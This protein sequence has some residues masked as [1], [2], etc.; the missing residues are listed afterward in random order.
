MTTPIDGVF[1][2]YGKANITDGEDW[3]RLDTLEPLSWRLQERGLGSATF[4][5]VDHFTGAEQSDPTP[6]SNLA[7][8]LGEGVF[9]VMIVNSSMLTD[10]LAATLPAEAPTGFDPGTLEW[11]GFLRTAPLL[12]FQNGG[13]DGL[14][15]G[16]E[17]GHYLLGEPIVHS[18]TIINGYN[19]V[20]DGTMYG[21]RLPLQETS[22]RTD[23]PER[24]WT[25]RQVV[26][27][28]A[29]KTSLS[30]Q[31]DWASEPDLLD[32]IESWPSYEGESLMTALEQ[33]IGPM[34]WR[35]DI[36]VDAN[37]VAI[38]VYSRSSYLGMD[39]EVAQT[40]STDERTLDLRI[41]QH[42]RP[43]DHIILRGQ[44]VLTTFTAST[45]GEEP[46]LVQGWAPL[47]ETP[48]VIGP[49]EAISNEDL[50]AEA[51]EALGDFDPNVWD[52]EGEYQTTLEQEIQR[53]TEAEF[54]RNAAW[55]RLNYPNM[56]VRYRWNYNMSTGALENYILPG[57]GTGGA[58]QSVPLS[59]DD[60]LTPV[61]PAGR[62]ITPFPRF[63][64]Q[65]T[66]SQELLAIP[67]VDGHAT[68]TRTDWTPHPTTTVP[69]SDD[70]GE[71]VGWHQPF[72]AMRCVGNISTQRRNDNT[73][74]RKQQWVDLTLPASGIQTGE[75]RYDGFAIQIDL[76]YPESLAA[77]YYDT[78]T[79]L[80]EVSGSGLAIRWSDFGRIQPTRWGPGPAGA[81]AR[82]PGRVEYI[83]KGHWSRIIFTI[84]VRSA[85]YVQL[86]HRFVAEPQRVKIVEDPDL[87]YWIYTRGTVVDF[88]NYDKANNLIFGT[89][90]A[91]PPQPELTDAVTTAPNYLG[92][93]SVE[94]INA[95]PERP[96]HED[97]F[98]TRDTLEDGMQRLEILKDWY[99]KQKTAVE[100][101]MPVYAA[102]ATD[103]G[104]P[105]TEEFTLTI[106]TLIDEV[107]DAQAL[108]EP[109]TVDTAISTIEVILG[110]TPI[111]R[112]VTEIPAA[113]P[114]S[115]FRRLID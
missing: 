22:R 81:A 112:V 1:K 9:W 64:F 97:Y 4:D 26:E 45:F 51:T 29:S 32:E 87:E 61:T 110:E 107:D 84:S 100:I 8:L 38:V 56:Y 20:I 36:T 3:V 88:L 30:L 49:P 76:P 62:K 19:P 2:V 96:P 41:V 60:Q 94:D 50:V 104:D 57:N 44:R 108:R 89:A 11:W 80:I 23:F 95:D 78:H 21:N 17:F 71:I 39:T 35:F 83:D 13:F 79:D 93:N 85:Q 63:Q 86:E 58:V 25:N 33:V 68:P 105:R 101:E 75:M 66:V 10:P 34:G 72:F 46:V 92:V 40:I 114:N 109:L 113:P 37:S 90:V 7:A 77:P 54:E 48:Y 70:D 18:G 115:R 53:F 5:T 42:E 12:Q 103:P 59:G 73:F 27:D 15:E 99:G 74:L 106:G 6:W 69:I 31:V 47:D 102:P 111:R 28:L 16:N 65:D 52:D 98:V 82:H 24:F 43:Y 55:R 91:D 67:V 14:I